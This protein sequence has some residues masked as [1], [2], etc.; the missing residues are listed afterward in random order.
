V[1]RHRNENKLRAALE[2]IWRNTRPEAISRLAALE[3]F[4]EKLLSGRADDECL[5]AARTAAHRLA[6]VLGM[7]GLEESSS[8]A[9]KIEGLLW[10]E[11]VSDAVLLEDLVHQL[12]HLLEGKPASMKTQEKRDL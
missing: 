1:T 10:Q 11:S 7:F 8:C 12:R 9:A 5:D 2:E 3:S 6:G 4:L